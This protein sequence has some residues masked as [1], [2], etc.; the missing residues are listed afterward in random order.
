MIRCIESEAQARIMTD[1]ELDH[2]IETFN[3]CR[4]NDIGHDKDAEQIL[5][6][7]KQIRTRI[8]ELNRKG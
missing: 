2:A 4:Y 1:I 7:E 3:M 6:I 8:K 5:I